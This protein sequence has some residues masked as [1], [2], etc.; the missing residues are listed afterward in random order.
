M[1]YTKARL[2]YEEADKNLDRVIT[3]ESSISPLGEDEPGAT[4]HRQK[5]YGIR[6]LGSKNL[7]HDELRELM[8]IAE[9]HSIEFNIK[10]GY[11]L[12]S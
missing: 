10:H 6:I 12:F 2:V 9:T 8:K 4:S 1:E 11:G 3:L 5:D 7:R